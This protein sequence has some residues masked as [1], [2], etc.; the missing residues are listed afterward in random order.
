MQKLFLA[1]WKMYLSDADAEALARAYLEGV[2][3][4]RIDAAVAPSFTALDRVSRVLRGSPVSLAAQDMFWADG[5]AYTGEI[6]PLQLTALGAR[7]VILGHSERRAY[8]GETDAMVAKKAAAAQGAG[9]APVI[10]VGET[11]EEWEAGNQQAVVRAQLE[12]ALKGLVFTAEKPVLVAYEPRWA[13]G[14]GAA[15]RVEDVVLMHGAIRTAVVGLAGNAALEHLR[16]LYGGSVDPK[17]IDEY[18]ASP[19]VDGV[20]VGG[21][22]TRPDDARALIEAFA[23]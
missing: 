4:S 17:N 3:A 10:C 13:I 20:L 19:A 9:L 15:C 16:V 6:S 14:T 21:A 18:L 22:G 8:L 1:N 11:K 2:L 5:G 23:R 7:Y 12:A